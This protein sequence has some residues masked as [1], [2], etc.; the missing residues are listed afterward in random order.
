[1]S[2]SAARSPSARPRVT[3]GGV[4]GTQPDRLADRL[5]Y[6]PKRADVARD[7]RPHRAGAA[8]Q[9]DPLDLSR[10]APRGDAATT[11]RRSTP[12]ASP[13]RPS[14]PKAALP[15]TIGPIPRPR[16]AARSTR[17]TQFISLVGLDRALAR[18][19]RRRQRHRQLHGEEAR[20]HR[21]LQDARR[22]EPARACRLSDPGAACS[23][24][25]A[26]SSGSCSARS[27]RAARRRSMAMRCPSRSRSSRI[28]CRC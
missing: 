12:R 24:A 20:G 14:S 9:P 22:L 11:R 7:A 15:S 16:S 8:G 3:I 4:L 19:H 10:E 23:P 17:F 13:S 25:S 18:R 2:R 27:P 26:S 28:P 1:M 6:G 5:A 21:H